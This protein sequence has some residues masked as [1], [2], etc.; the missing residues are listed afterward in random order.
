MLSLDNPAVLAW[1]ALPYSFVVD[2]FIPIGDYL[3]E[4]LNLSGP[5][6]IDEMSVTELTE[7]TLNGYGTFTEGVSSPIANKASG[8]CQHTRRYK[9]RTKG[10]VS[11]PL[12]SFNN[13]F[14]SLDRF[15]NQLALFKVEVNRRL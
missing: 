15:Y 4:T 6:R 13:P 3:N 12:P 7:T 8:R 11:R 9:K 5:I 2:W 10:V 14:T 1:E